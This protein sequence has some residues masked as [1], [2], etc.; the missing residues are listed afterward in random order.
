MFTWDLQKPLAKQGI[1]NAHQLATFARLS[2][3][4]AE[5]VWANEP[6]ARLDAKTVRKLAD[7][8]GIK[9]RLSIV[10]LE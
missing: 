8:F 1:Q 2:Y 9:R 7:A 6:M 10:V 4:V 3:P 5:R